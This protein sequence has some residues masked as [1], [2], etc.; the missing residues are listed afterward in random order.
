[1][2]C[3]NS[4]TWI[5]N[6]QL[7]LYLGYKRKVSYSHYSHTIQSYKCIRVLC[8]SGS[9]CSS[10]HVLPTSSLINSKTEVTSQSQSK[11]EVA[12]KLPCTPSQQNTTGAS[13]ADVRSY[14]ESRCRAGPH[15][16]T[17]SGELLCIMPTSMMGH[18]ASMRILANYYPGTF[19]RG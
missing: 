10:S 2:L 9:L 16:G 8:S 19:V 7:S 12:G 4:V 14:G 13:F 15:E 5:D 1:L 11:K 3:N 6:T 18:L 17:S